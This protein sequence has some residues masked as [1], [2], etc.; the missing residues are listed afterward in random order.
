MTMTLWTAFGSK[1]TLG[2]LWAGALTGGQFRGP[3]E[4][5]LRLTGA[6]SFLILDRAIVLCPFGNRAVGTT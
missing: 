1:L 4:L 5:V 6:A 3:W 2:Q